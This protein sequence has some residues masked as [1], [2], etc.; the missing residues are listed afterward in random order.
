MQ[1]QS[2]GRKVPGPSPLTR[3]RQEYTRLIARGVSNAEACRL[4]GVNRRT[5]TRWRYGRTVPTRAGGEREYPAMIEVTKQT[6]PRRSSRYLSEAER[7]V[8][9]DRRRAHASMRA[10][11]RELGRNV[12]SVS[13]ELG[14]N[15]DEQG[16]YRPSAAQRMATAR[17]ARP[18][19]RKV[20]ADR[21][22]GALVQGWLDLLWSP[23]QISAALAMAF[24]NDPGRRLAAETIYQAL[25]AK[26]SV[27]QRDP[28]TCL[29]SRRRR[30]RPHRRG[31]ARRKRA[32]VARP[33][34]SERPPEAE[35][36]IVPGHWEGDLITGAS[37]RSAIAT[38]IERASGYTVLVHVP[39]RHSADVLTPGLVAAFTALPTSLRRSLTWDCGTEMSD[40]PV[41]TAATGMPV[42]FADPHSPWQRGSNENTNGLLRQY[43]PKGSNLAIHSPGRLAEVQD[44]LNGR[45]RKRHQWSTPS[46]RL[47][48]LQSPHQ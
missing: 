2:A 30:R 21:P 29:R 17:L 46:T 6:P 8:I 19:V 37:N 12:S 38:L 43:F 25:Y 5:G 45:P 34:I 28:A 36:R 15:R 33:S 23:E 1:E 10:I 35:D 41:L 14:R 40:H 32:Q 18:R 27:L 9:A 20:A 3:Q 11:A 31:D 4:V 13:R 24:P 47:A 42:F 22:L 26:E 39:G 16:R 7:E 48:A 44:E